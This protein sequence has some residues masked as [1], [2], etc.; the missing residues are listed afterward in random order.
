MCIRNVLELPV[1]K[2]DISLTEG[3]ALHTERWLVKGKGQQR[4][5]LTGKPRTS[6]H[7][8]TSQ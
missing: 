8:K 6:G 4:N 7:S 3:S 5:V 1:K 2:H